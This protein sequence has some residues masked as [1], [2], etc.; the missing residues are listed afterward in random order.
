MKPALIYSLKVWLTSVV[1]SPILYIIEEY[2]THPG[3]YKWEG[4]TGFVG[5]SFIY[6]ALL[7][8][9][10]YGLFA[11]MTYSINKLK[12]KILIKKIY[13][14]VICTILC[15][16]PFYLLDRGSIFLVSDLRWGCFYCFVIIA[17]IWFYELV[18]A[19]KESIEGLNPKQ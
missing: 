15:M 4:I 19:T 6:S 17:A 18:P 5:L 7:S 3:Y 1:L 8:I 13:L 16:F 11:Y 14:T 10:S 2:L 9:P 12:T